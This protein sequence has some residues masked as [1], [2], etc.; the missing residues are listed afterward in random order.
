M[1]LSEQEK[2]EL[3]E[4]GKDIQRREDFRKA[5]NSSLEINFEEYLLWLEEVQKVGRTNL[6]RKFVFYKTVKL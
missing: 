4:D 1:K 5:K 3:L 6:D 2:K